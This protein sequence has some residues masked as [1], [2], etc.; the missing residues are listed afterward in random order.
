MFQCRVPRNQYQSKGSS[1]Q[2]CASHPVVRF[3]TVTDAIVEATTQS[4][5]LRSMAGKLAS[6]LSAKS[7]SRASAAAELPLTTMSNCRSDMALE[8][9]LVALALACFGLLACTA[10]QKGSVQTRF[11]STHKS[12]RCCSGMDCL[13][14]TDGAA[15]HKY[16]FVASMRSAEYLVLLRE[17]QCSLQLTNP[18]IPLV[19]IAVSG[20]LDDAV[21][22][23]VREI[24][25]YVEVNDIVVP[26]TEPMRSRYS[27]NWVKLQAWDLTQYSAIIMLDLDMIVLTDVQHVFA[28][29]TDFAWTYLNAPD[30]WDWNKGGFIMLRPCHGVFQHMMDLLQNVSDRPFTND[31]YAE[32]SFLAWYFAFVG[33]RLPMTYNANAYFLENGLTAGGEKPIALHFAFGD[34]KPFN[35]IENDTEWEYMCHRYNR[36]HGTHSRHFHIAQ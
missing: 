26:G 36:H 15:N 9:M 19:V 12:P 24:A 3:E 32:Q 27:K 5:M 7:S 10:A 2:N 28:L 14:S 21:V 8:Q 17:L 20:D 4:S 18:S 1:K 23:E 33:F 29:P 34:H 22:S 13:S 25:E 35:V 11:D 30:S 16:A 31:D 6:G